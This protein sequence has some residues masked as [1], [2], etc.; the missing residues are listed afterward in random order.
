MMF[1]RVLKISI[2]ASS[3]GAVIIAGCSENNR[4][5]IKGQNDA[6]FYVDIS[7]VK[8]SLTTVGD[9]NSQGKHDQKLLSMEACI[10]D[11]AQT[12]STTNLPFE[13]AAGDVST[14][15]RTD[16]RGCLMWQELVEFD[17]QAEEKN[18]FMSRKITAKESHEGTTKVVFAVNPYKDI[19]TPNPLGNGGGSSSSEPVSY[20]L[21]DLSQTASRN[22][23]YDIYVKVNE[24]VNTLLSPIKRQ[25]EVT[26]LKLDFR[27]IDYPN[28]LVDQK[29]NISF[30]YIYK[31]SL[32]IDIIRQDLGTI[33][34]E[35]I[36]RG[37][38]QFHLVFLKNMPIVKDPKAVDVLAAVQ[39]TAKPRGDAG[40]IEVPITVNFNNIGA[41]S[42][43]LSVLLTIT[44][45]DTPALFAD[46]SYEGVV[47]GIAANQN[48][49]ISLI[50][51]S[52]SARDLMTEFDTLKNKK[53]SAPSL[54]SK[55]VLESEGFKEIKD[56]S[57]T[58]QAANGFFSKP[59]VKTVELKSL[60][61][62]SR[63]N[64]Q[65]DFLEKRAV[66]DLFFDSSASPVM[67][68]LKSRCHLNPDSVLNAEVREFIESV[69]T[70]PTQV[71][72]GRREI[73]TNTASIQLSQS[74][75]KTSGYGLDANVGGSLDLG[76]STGLQGTIPVPKAPIGAKLGLGL[77]LGVG[78]KAFATQGLEKLEKGAKEVSI[79]ATETLSSDTIALTLNVVIKKCLLVAAKIGTFES[80]GV[81]PTSRYVCSDVVDK[82]QRTEYFFL[83]N[84]EKVAGS[85]SVADVYS[86]VVNPL[87]LLVRGDRPYEFLKGILTSEKYSYKIFGTMNADQMTDDPSNFI[88]QEA[89]LML[90]SRKILLG[91]VSR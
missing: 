57:V 7:T 52:T 60:V 38:F 18:I 37:N 64:T 21:K 54:T 76:A 87:R 91:T 59:Q 30:P 29:L 53:V 68:N 26:Q 34:S 39:F 81:K 6:T 2:V 79:T 33:L 27:S 23:D 51:N 70:N 4:P 77:N 9:A 43:R 36:K 80:E 50:Q 25:T 62:N 58:V 1:S 32:S 19:F 11:N 35:K 67:A 3:I 14:I 65:L 72:F 61:D 17:P 46:Q 69:D 28:I 22:F 78:G 85:S 41:I 82:V 55:S 40:L 45:L 73:L 88:T 44:S 89:P 15:K 24:D 13:I 20:K 10:K 48:L 47:N 63:D 84:H 8:G 66:C 74:K 86:A 71:N 90:S 56:S 5:Q 75:T 16:Y 42:N 49:E 31:T 12:N 83:L